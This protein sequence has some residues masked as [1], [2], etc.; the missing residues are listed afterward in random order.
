MPTWI[1]CRGSVPALVAHS[2]SGQAPVQGGFLVSQGD[3]FGGS[4]AHIWVRTLNYPTI[5]TAGVA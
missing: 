2:A 5:I 1:Q 4:A 3:A